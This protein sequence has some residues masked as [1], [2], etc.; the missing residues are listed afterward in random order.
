MEFSCNIDELDEL[1]LTFT[2]YLILF[3]IY[4]QV[5]YKN[6]EINEK[7]YEK[8][9]NKSYIGKTEEG[10]YV[11]LDKGFDFFVPPENLFSEFIETFPT[12]VV[13][14]AS[15]SIRI[16]SPASANTV[17]GKKLKKKW[18]SISK[19][20]NDFQRHV[21]DC[22]KAEIRNRTTTNSLQWMRNAETWLNNGTWED[23]AY[24]LDKPKTD[25][26][27]KDIRL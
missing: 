3:S 18:D 9:E 11:L 23:F 8:L 12:R 21:I 22:L 10:T 25:L 2:E 27:S 14:P 15:G 24:L 19:G 4:N 6:I 20:K 26:S 5:V 7:V 13:D 1:G 17:A 16:L